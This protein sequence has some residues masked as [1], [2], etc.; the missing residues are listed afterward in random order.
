M[1]KSVLSMLSSRSFIVYGLTFTSLIH[2]E[3]IFCMVLENV[4]IHSFTGHCSVF[5]APLIEETVF[6]PLYILASFVID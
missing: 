2:F 3:F 5:P 1:S 6:Y 4:L